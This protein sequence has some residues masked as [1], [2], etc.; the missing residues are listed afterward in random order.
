MHD[1]QGYRS[2]YIRMSL[3]VI[4]ID[5][6]YLRIVMRDVLR[7]GEDFCNQCI[8]L[9]SIQARHDDAV[10]NEIA[11]LCNLCNDLCYTV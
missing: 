5:V 10:H 6:C 8:R 2:G 3:Y 9:L 1:I 4:W 7:F 11:N